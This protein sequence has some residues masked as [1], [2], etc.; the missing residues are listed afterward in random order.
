MN[1]T[2][3]KP[4]NT[5][6]NADVGRL[7]GPAA[8]MLR[9]RLKS[10]ARGMV[11]GIQRTAR[12][13]LKNQAFDFGCAIMDA[14]GNLVEEDE[15]RA[16]FP[17]AIHPGCQALARRFAGRVRPG[18]VFMHN[19]VFTGN[20]Q[21]N[22]AGFYVP[23]FVDGVLVGWT[24]AKGH[25]ADL[26]G[27]VPSS[28]NPEA[29]DY[30]GEGLRIPAV[31]VFDAGEFRD[32]VWDMIFSNFRLPD[33]DGP[34]MLGMIGACQMG[35]RRVEEVAQRL[36]VANFERVVHGL[37]DMTE[38]MMRDEIRL[39]PDGHYSAKRI[40]HVDKE[41]QE[42]ATINL[43]VVVEGDHLTFDYTGSSAQ[44][45]TYCNAPLGSTMAGIMTYLSMILD[46]RLPH[47][48]GMY[49]PLTF[50]IP[51]GTLLNPKPP[52]ATYYGNFMS[53]VNSEAIMLAFGQ[54]VPHRVTAGW[55]RP[56]SLQITAFDP[57]RDKRY[58][59]IDFI[60][61]KGGSGATDGHDG[62]NNGPIFG[63]STLTN[64][65]EFF[66]LQDPHVM[67]QHEFKEDSSG[68]GKWRG[69]NGA[70]TRWRF[71]GRDPTLVLQG[72]L[73]GGFGIFGGTA[74]TNNSFRLVFPDGEIYKPGAKE[75]IRR[76]IPPGTIVERHSGGGGGFG[77][78][79]ERTP[80]AIRGDV[81]DGLVSAEKA[82]VDYGVVI[83]NLTLE[84]D[85]DATGQARAR[86]AKL[87][88]PDE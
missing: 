11:I 18:D 74:G 73:E 84:I 44:T 46:P 40:L 12:S 58:G 47:N 43:T 1:Q 75:I 28:C 62:W 35:A 8:S 45:P 83:D 34:D 55:T 23:A 36:G 52:A 64:D 60:A 13:P 10:F 39:I 72:E 24:G 38:G 32:D 61:L 27:P 49:R 41:S 2:D 14:T 54:A 79:L 53:A 86:A 66:E 51:E 31:K 16:L 21:M 9:T 50:V 77:D 80:D 78:P 71:E 63:V 68:S 6:N 69:G 82:L 25:M 17:F 57:R 56:M 76:P 87:P 33:I 26:G 20:L 37:F 42:P 59:D 70:I 48:D 81:R 88:S 30:F 3:R 5:E 15:F 19:D 4:I 7:M 22:D 29:R 67:L 85:L 65:Y